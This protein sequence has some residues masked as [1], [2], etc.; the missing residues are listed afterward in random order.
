MFVIFRLY[1]FI[2]SSNLFIF[3]SLENP[4]LRSHG[5]DC[6]LMA[7][8]LFADG[9]EMLQEQ[10]AGSVCRTMPACRR[11]FPQ[12]RVCLELKGLVRVGIEGELD[13]LPCDCI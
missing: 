10:V 7:R 2:Y 8:R 1:L 4:K 9:A 6:L 11:W 12:C 13:K 3:S 5:A